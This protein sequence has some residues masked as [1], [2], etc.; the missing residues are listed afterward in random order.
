MKNQ[1]QTSINHHY[2]N[3]KMTPEFKNQVIEQLDSSETTTARPASRS[4]RHILAAA[5]ILCIVLTSSVTVLGATL[6]S[7]NSL[8]SKVS[9]SYAALL[10]PVSA[11]IEDN[12]IE[13]RLIS[14][15]ADEQTILVVLEAEDL[16]GGD[17]VEMIT[18]QI[19]SDARDVTGRINRQYDQ[20]TGIMTYF[21]IGEYIS[22]DKLE[23]VTLTI[24][25]M[26]G[27]GYGLESISPDEL[28]G[29]WQLSFT[30]EILESEQLKANVMIKNA[31]IDSSSI[32]PLSLRLSG[33]EEINI[34]DIYMELTMVDGTIYYI[35]SDVRKDVITLDGS[36]TT[37][38]SESEYDAIIQFGEVLDLDQIESV[39]VCD[40]TLK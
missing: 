24:D 40:V 16:T 30:P 10:M 39:V 8:I 15:I 28:E 3:Y 23:E 4:Y 11:A 14:A 7:V 9:P 35:G 27:S 6:S 29:D 38:T 17:R 19:E 34:S 26:A 2:R 37:S 12:D 20:E 25:F 1:L 18:P 31:V 32:T 22:R 33:S 5:A 13:V 21:W 36:I